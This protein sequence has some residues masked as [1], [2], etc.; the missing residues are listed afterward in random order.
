MA[1]VLYNQGKYDEALGWYRRVLT[2][3]EKSLGKGHPETLCAVYC[4]AN[5]FWRQG[6]YD[7]AVEWYRRVLDGRESS[8]GNDHPDTLVTV[9]S[10]ANSLG[11]RGTTT[12]H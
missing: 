3:F 1:N 8:L 12:K 7:G 5:V 9:C 4:M 11:G 2:R 6:K 10:I